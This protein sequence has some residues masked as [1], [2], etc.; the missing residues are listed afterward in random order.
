MCFSST[1]WRLLTLTKTQPVKPY[2][3][4]RLSPG[5][6]SLAQV[7]MQ[8]IPVFL[9]QALHDVEGALAQGLT[10]GVKENQDQVT[11]VAWEWEGPLFS[12]T[13]WIPGYKMSKALYL[14]TA[15]KCTVMEV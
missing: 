3:S 4:V 12:K 11:E 15:L 14:L 7:K 9:I 5:L 1:E 13:G 6:V 2:L 8:S 10:H